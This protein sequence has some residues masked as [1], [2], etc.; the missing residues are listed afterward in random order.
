MTPREWQRLKVGDVLIDKSHRN[1]R[2]KILSIGR[3]RGKP[4]QRGL[5]RTAMR[6]TSLKSASGSTVIFE[7]ENTGPARFDLASDPRGAVN[8]EAMVQRD[9]QWR[10]YEPCR[11]N[12]ERARRERD[13]AADDAM[14]ER[15]AFSNMATRALTSHMTIK[16]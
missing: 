15:A 9:K 10:D 8:R 12:E 1:A 7:S 11:E 13:G 3:V 4:E 2:R 16:P 6:V 14:F 5:T